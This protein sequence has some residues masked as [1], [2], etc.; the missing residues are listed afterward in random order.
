M[1]CEVVG[2]EGAVDVEEGGLGRDVEKGHDAL[3]NHFYI[4]H[5]E[6]KH[7]FVLVEYIL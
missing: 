1:L 7:I 3:V 2:E 4:L 6:G 5:L